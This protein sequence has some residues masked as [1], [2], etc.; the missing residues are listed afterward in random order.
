MF[1]TRD[2]HEGGRSLRRGNEFKLY[3]QRVRLDIAKYA[4]ANRMCTS[5]KNLPKEVVDRGCKMHKYVQGRT[6]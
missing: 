5:W 4:F 2:D 3:K 1:L 6:R